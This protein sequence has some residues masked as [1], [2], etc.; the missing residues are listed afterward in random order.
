METTQSL[1]FLGN[2]YISTL[3]HSSI[4]GH[5]ALVLFPLSSVQKPNIQRNIQQDC[6]EKSSISHNKYPAGTH[7][8][9]AL[10]NCGYN[11]VTLEN[12]IANLWTG[13]V[14]VLL[15][16]REPIAIL[17]TA[18]TSDMC[19]SRLNSQQWPG[20]ITA[21]ISLNLYSCN[22]FNQIPDS[23]NF[24]RGRCHISKTQWRR[25]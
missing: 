3:F 17:G 15:E 2:L 9:V 5:Q 11:I 19:G 8:F 21:I 22:W 24:F 4:M 6:S 14:E 23:Q 13:F 16:Q 1:D 12:G 10:V 18:D 7:I 25:I 20:G